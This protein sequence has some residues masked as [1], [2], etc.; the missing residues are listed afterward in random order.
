LQRG[1]GH[2]AVAVALAKRELHHFIVETALHAE[3]LL[4]QAAAGQGGCRK[5]ERLGR[6][7]DEI[8]GAGRPRR[9]SPEVGRSE[10]D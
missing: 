1:R 10:P 5:P 3:P 8:L 2:A 7:L 6:F 9:F 4:A